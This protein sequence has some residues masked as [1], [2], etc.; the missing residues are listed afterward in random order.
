MFTMY[1]LPTSYPE[2]AAAWTL[3]KGQRCEEPTGTEV[4]VR[5]GVSEMLKSQVSTKTAKMAEEG[6]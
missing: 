6:K 4:S 1:P 5:T 2:G 3:T